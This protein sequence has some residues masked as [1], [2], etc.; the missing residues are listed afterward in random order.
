M[1]AGIRIVITFL[2]FALLVFAWMFHLD[3]HPSAGAGVYIINRWAGAIYYCA[4]ASDCKQ[5]F[6]K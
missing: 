5:V 1:T 4:V 6:P 3:V 2:S